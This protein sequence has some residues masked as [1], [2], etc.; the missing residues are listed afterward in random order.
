VERFLKGLQEF[1]SKGVTDVPFDEA[2][3]K[4]YDASGVKTYL[5]KMTVGSQQA[6]ARRIMMDILKSAPSKGRDERKPKQKP[7]RKTPIR[8]KKTSPMA[9]P[10]SPKRRPAAK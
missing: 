4:K 1:R 5:D 7:A 9:K 6:I 2:E 10:G 8:K 3:I